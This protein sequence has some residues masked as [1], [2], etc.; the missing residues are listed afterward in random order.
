MDIIDID[1]IET[2]ATIMVGTCSHVY[3]QSCI[4][5]WL[6]VANTCPLCNRVWETQS[7]GSA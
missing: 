2:C 1:T 4:H 7:I 5:R 3:H 6:Q